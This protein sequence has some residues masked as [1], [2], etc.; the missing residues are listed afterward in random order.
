MHLEEVPLGELAT[1]LGITGLRIAWN[2]VPETWNVITPEASQ[3][4]VVLSRAVSHAVC[5]RITSCVSPGD[6]GW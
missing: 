5:H 2:T 1:F 4:W 3:T 6:M